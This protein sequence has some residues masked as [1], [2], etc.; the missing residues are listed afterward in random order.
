MSR[1]GISSK[2]LAGESIS[3]VLES[4]PDNIQGYLNPYRKVI[5]P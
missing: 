1:R 5:W 3:F 2:S 4:M